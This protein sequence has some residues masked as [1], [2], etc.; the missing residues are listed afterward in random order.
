MTSFEI[1]DMHQFVNGAY[2]QDGLQHP[3]QPQHRARFG[4]AGCA[5]RNKSSTMQCLIDFQRHDRVPPS[6]GLSSCSHW[7]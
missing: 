3:V 5:N 2:L 1:L 4:R 7:K 6:H